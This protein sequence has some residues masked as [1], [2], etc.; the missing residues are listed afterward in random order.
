MTERKG[1]KQKMLRAALQ[2]FG[3]RGYEAVTVAQIADVVGCTAPALYKHYSGKQELF[4]AILEESR[5][6]WQASMQRVLFDISDEEARKK[7]VNLTEEEQI[8]M[9]Q[10]LLLHP[11]HDEMARAFRRLMEVEQFHFPALAETYNQRY[12][13]F[14]YQQHASLFRCLM[15]EGRMQQGDPEMLSVCYVSPIIVFIGMCDRA[16]ERETE[17]LEKIAAHVRAFNR[18]YMIM[19]EEEA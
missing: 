17:A 18:A 9:A 2:L 7:A 11:L 8:A 13:D 3:D 4:E 12:V 6:G 16:P 14:P 5:I 1:T 15:E 10:Q 19:K